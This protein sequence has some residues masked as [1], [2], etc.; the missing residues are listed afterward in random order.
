MRAT[1]WMLAAAV[2]L[3]ASAAA[4]QPWRYVGADGAVHWT[5]NV[6]ELPP[7]QR[8]AILKA[9]EEAEARKAEQQQKVKRTT[10]AARL[11]PAP[12][13]APTPRPAP[14]APQ[15]VPAQRAVPPVPKMTEGDQRARW[16]AR[17]DD[18]QAALA[19]AKHRAEVKRLEAEAAN[20]AAGPFAH[21]AKIAEA[22]EKRRAH[23]AAQ[24]K[25]K[26]AED[27]IIRLREE[28][29]RAGVPPGWVR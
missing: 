18:L 6:H 10:P 9:Q 2:L 3:W 19:D 29:R 4:A 20:R 24:A 17:L 21:Q 15:A 27:A 16:R 14:V 28:A 8:D 12:E 5:N 25:V 7:K 11:R 23:E 26:A 13:P 22:Q 1:G